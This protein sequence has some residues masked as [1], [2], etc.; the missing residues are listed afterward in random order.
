VRCGHD[1]DGTNQFQAKV[2]AHR[3]EGAHTVYTL[4]AWAAKLE[5][6]ELGTS[7]R[8]RKSDS[9]IDIT[10]PAGLVAGAFGGP[11]SHQ[12]SDRQK[13]SLAPRAAKA[14]AKLRRIQVSTAG[15]R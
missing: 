7:A 12:T 5:V 14:A 9:T 15:A 8:H 13:A 3:F 6:L 2:L 4:A 1:G 11:R 10:V